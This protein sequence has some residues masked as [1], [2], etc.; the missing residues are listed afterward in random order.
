[1]AVA[2]FCLFVIARDISARRTPAS[3]NGL[4]RP[5][6]K[7]SGGGVYCHLSAIKDTFN[8]INS[9]SYL[10]RIAV[11]SIIFSRNCCTSATYL[12]ASL[13][14]SQGL[15]VTLGLNMLEINYSAEGEKKDDGASNIFLVFSDKAQQPGGIFIVKRLIM[16][17]DRR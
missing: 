16:L 1:M 3:I 2:R 4:E 14:I 6:R 17:I 15:S 5:R 8:R 13:I 10:A 7:E 9:S 11:Q 12:G